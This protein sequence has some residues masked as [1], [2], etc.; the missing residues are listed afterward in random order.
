MSTTTR[1]Q[2]GQGSSLQKIF[3][4]HASQKMCP[5]FFLSPALALEIYDSGQAVRKKRA[6]RFLVDSESSDHR[7]LS[8]P[9]LQVFFFVSE[10]TG[11]VGTK[12]QKRG[13]GAWRGQLR[14]GSRVAEAVEA[15]RTGALSA[16]DEG[17]VLTLRALPVLGQDFG[18]R[19]EFD[20]R[21]VEGGR[22]SFVCF[23]YCVSLIETG[24]IQKRLSRR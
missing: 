2:V 23:E 3:L 20:L 11:Y 1:R 6:K 24:A 10:S 12:S 5:Q 18:V 14:S 15:D 8:F 4:Q 9:S 22:F 13:S 16:L 21:G 17:D 19:V 7:F